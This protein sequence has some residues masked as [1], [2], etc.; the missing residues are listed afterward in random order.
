MKAGENMDY[1]HEYASP[2]GTIRMGSDGKY[3]IG[4]WF[5]DGRHAGETLDKEAR[6][7]DD[8]SVFQ[9]TDAWLDQY[10]AGKQPDFLPP[11]LVRGSAFRQR[12]CQLLLNIPYGKT[13]TY[14][15]LA[16]KIAQERGKAKMSAQAVGGAVGH[17]PISLIIPCHRVVGSN[18][19]LTGYGGGIDRKIKLLQLE[20]MD[21]TKFF[22]PKHGTAL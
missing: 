12:V 9:Q 15:E 22:V 7:K 18:G 5:A 10:F 11:L 19:S 21:T 4:L 16:K 6:E 17:N 1:W 2:L 20:H 8:L 3:L 14:G 13:V